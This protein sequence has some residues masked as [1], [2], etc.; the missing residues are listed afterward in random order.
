MKYGDKFLQALQRL[1]VNRR[2]WVVCLDRKLREPWFRVL[3]QNRILRGP[4]PCYFSS[5]SFEVFE[6][7]Q[8]NVVEE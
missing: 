5:P 8:R 4:T 6:D 7:G 2:W 1:V 3:S